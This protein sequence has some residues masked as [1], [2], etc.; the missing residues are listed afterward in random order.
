MIAL[1][2]AIILA[3]CAENTEKKIQEFEAQHEALMTEFSAALDSLQN[4]QA[5][6]QAFYDS[7]VEKY[8][9]FNIEAAMDNLKNE[10][11]V[12]A[13]K[14]LRGLIEDDQVAEIMDGMAPELLQNEEVAEMK[15]SLD[16]RIATSEGKPYVDFTVENVY[17]YD[18]SA[19]P[20]PLKQEV[21]FSDY[22]GKG[23]Y[24]LVDFWSPWCGPC[25][26]EMPNIKTVY[27][28]YKDKGLEVIS[29]TVWERKPQSHTFET[30]AQLEMDWTILT[31]CGRIPSDIYGVESI[32][33]LMLIGPDG[34]ILKR[35][36]YGLEGIESAVAEHIN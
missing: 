22:V 5:A 20:Q 2:P 23:K 10:I 11:S 36:F 25:R 9:D 33:H 29:L 18:R 14:N 35:G 4:D 19:D 13:L 6:A 3:G 31:N 12:M 34:T 17:G 7:F 26:R 1:F 24:L 21:K 30:A 32:P 27:E 15:K 16:A 8:L 28:K